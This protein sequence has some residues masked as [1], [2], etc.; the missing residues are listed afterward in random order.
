MIAKKLIKRPIKVGDDVITLD[1]KIIGNVESFGFS[2]KVNNDGTFKTITTA[3]LFIDKT[4]RKSVYLKDLRHLTEADLDPK[5]TKKVINKKKS[6][7][8]IEFDKAV[9]ELIPNILDDMLSIRQSEISCGIQEV[10]GLCDSFY[11]MLCSFRQLNNIYG[12][13]FEYVYGIETLTK[14][15]Y[16]KLLLA[17]FKL[18]FIEYLRSKVAE[19]A[20]ILVSLPYEEKYEPMIAL[21]DKNAQSYTEWRRNPNSGNMIKVWI[22]TSS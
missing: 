2:G 8:I 9:D 7:D 11:E 18:I 13:I 6:L 16:D 14:E 20:F 19:C 22:L 10:N 15:K 21:L 4:T 17:R 12:D 1:G 5:P 3:R